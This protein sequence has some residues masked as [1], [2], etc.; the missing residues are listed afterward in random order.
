MRRRTPWQT[1][2]LKADVAS[3]LDWIS[4]GGDV[5][6][7]PTND[8]RMATLL[9]ALFNTNAL[10][11]LISVDETNLN[12]WGATLDGLT[13]LSNSLEDPF[14]GEELQFDTIVV[15]SNAPQVSTVVDDIN[16]ARAQH[17][18]YFAGADALFSVASLSSD[19]PWLNLTGEQTRFGITDEA[20]EALPGQLLSRVRSNPVAAILR[21][22]NSI[23]LRFRGLGG[24]LF[25]IE[26]SP[27]LVT[28]TSV[29]SPRWSANGFFSMTLSPTLDWQF[30]RAVLHP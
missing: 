7:H 8:W 4:A 27:N 10:N 23:E 18:G 17:G 15:S 1:I 29:G 25:Q 3:L 13:V 24:Y 9:A 22:E 19:S 28:W 6:T 2:Y 12:V 21:D 14:L 20:Y 30:F 16:Q 5:R 26:S 11:N